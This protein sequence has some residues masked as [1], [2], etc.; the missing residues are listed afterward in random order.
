MMAVFPRREARASTMQHVEA[1]AA[2]WHIDSSASI[3]IDTSTIWRRRSRPFYRQ[4]IM[5]VIVVL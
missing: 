1:R 4:I 3:D 2:F 5:A